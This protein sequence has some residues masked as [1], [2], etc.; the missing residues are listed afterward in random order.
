MRTAA[1]IL[2]ASLIIP[3]IVVLSFMFI[4]R[5]D[6]KNFDREMTKFE[7]NAIANAMGYNPVMDSL[8]LK[9]EKK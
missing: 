7:N 8:N 9:K 3:V 4:E 2:S 1:M 5:N 6:M